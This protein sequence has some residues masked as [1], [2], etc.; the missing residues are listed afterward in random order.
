M[1]RIV[2]AVPIFAVA[3][4][5]LLV[6]CSGSSD[7]DDAPVQRNPLLRADDFNET[8]PDE[9][10]VTLETTAGDVV[11]H[12]YR[13]WAPLGADRFYNLAKG[14]FYDDSRI[15]RIVPGFMAQFGLNADPYVNQV[16]KKEFLVDDP[17]AESNTRGRVA[18]A[19]GGRHTRTTEVF[20]SYKDNSALDDEGFAPFGEVVDGMDVVDA[21]YSEYGDGP[22][23]GEGPYQAM[24]QARGNEYL[25][26]EFPELTRILK[27]T[28]TPGG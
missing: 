20:I 6:G 17:V 26:A 13:Q 2:S 19:K 15:Y 5:L 18:F 10:R 11:I 24:A 23:R 28:V 1:K 16:W 12:V 25:D 21:F 22:P 14:G 8:A 9:Y 4:P 3:L 27:A 7:G